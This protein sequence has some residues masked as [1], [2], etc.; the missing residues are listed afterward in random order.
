[1]SAHPVTDQPTFSTSEMNSRREFLALLA[2]SAGMA[3]LAGCGA[4]SDKSTPSSVLLGVPP[5]LQGLSIFRDTLVEMPWPAI[6]EAAQNGAIVLLPVG[7]IEAHGPHMG[8]AADIIQA[9]VTT[10]LVRLA[11]EPK[12]YQ[13]LIAPPCYWGM[14]P[15]VAA[16][17]GTFSVRGTT[18]NA[19][20]LDLHSNLRDWGFKY[21]FSFNAHGSS[22]HNR[23]L[24]ETIQ[25]A[26]EGL[27]IG[28]YYIGS[29]A[30]TV[31]NP[32]YAI[33]PE[34]PPLPAELGKYLDVHAGAFE[35]AAMKILFPGT[36]DTKLAKTLKPTTSFD[37]LGYWGDPASYDKIDPEVLTHY[38]EASAELTAQAI[39]DFLKEKG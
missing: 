19:I 3:L 31:S 10:R 1:M 17:P 22:I 9:Y 15:E 14:S 6:K 25:E 11:L 8:L 26:N 5:T 23:V 36:V 27:G 20:L 29:K 30:R 4:A 13:A 38:A 28:A 16:Y 2:A 7:M 35:T 39:A 37:P 18:L 32:R 34:A 33:F 12:G 24:Q 21:V